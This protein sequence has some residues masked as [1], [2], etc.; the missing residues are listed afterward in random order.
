MAIKYRIVT[1]IEKYDTETDDILDTYMAQK[2]MITSKKVRIMKI[3]KYPHEECIIAIS[4]NEDFASVLYSKSKLINDDIKA[5][6]TCKMDDLGFSDIY[7]KKPGVY[8][9][10]GTIIHCSSAP[11]IIDEVEYVANKY[12]ML[13]SFD[14][15]KVIQLDPWRNDPDYPTEDWTDEVIAGATR[16]G[17]L[18]WVDHQRAIKIDDQAAA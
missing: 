18:A 3:R 1:T 14:P 17:Y 4:N 13:Y 12:D 16:L 15:A 6:Q 2:S 8:R 10:T 9:W 7:P 5:Q 11:G